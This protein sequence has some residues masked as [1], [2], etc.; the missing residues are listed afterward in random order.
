MTSQ[1]KRERRTSPPSYSRSVWT[2]FFISE[3]PRQT[4]AHLLS[5]LIILSIRITSLSFLHKANSLTHSLLATLQYC[6]MKLIDTT[7]TL[8][9]QLR[10]NHHRVLQQQQFVDLPAASTT[11]CPDFHRCYNGAPCVEHET[12]EGSYYCNCLAIVD[13]NDIYAGLSCEHVATSYCNDNGVVD[14]ISFCT[15]DG[16]CQRM[17]NYDDHTQ[18]DHYHG[19]CDCL[20]GYKGDVSSIFEGKKKS[21]CW[22]SA[23]IATTF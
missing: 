10:R 2:V 22:I 8:P 18:Q 20:D 23:V 15:N 21:A 16:S 17:V 12:N 7:T 6:T 14:P 9:L 5:C 13:Q 4:S 1:A 19:G 3:Q 11:I